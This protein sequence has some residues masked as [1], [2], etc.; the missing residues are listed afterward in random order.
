MDGTVTLVLLRHG[1]SEWNLENRFTGWADVELSP[2]GR[3]EAAAAGGLMR[4][5]GLRFDVCFT[6]RLKRA[7]HTLALALEELGGAPPCIEDWR[8]NERHYGALQGL[9]KAETAARYGEEQVKLWRRSYDV[10]PPLLEPGDPRSPANQNRYKD[11]PRRLLPLGESLADTV[12]RVNPFFQSEV[13]P[14]LSAGRSVLI[15]AHGNSLRALIMALEGL[16]SAE[17]AQV[18]VPTGI[19]LRYTLSPGLAVVEKEYLG[20]PARLAAGIARAAGQ[21]KKIR[22]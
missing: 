18:D 2:A 21:G 14:L 1:E 3:R 17:I 12:A 9:N 22:A 7:G 20:D 10:R 11:V 4:E 19:P 16:T 13:R 15:T 6:S 8:L 5:A